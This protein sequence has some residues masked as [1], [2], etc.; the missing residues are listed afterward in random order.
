MNIRRWWASTAALAFA[1]TLAQACSGRGG[2][3]GGLAGGFD[4]TD[5]DAAAVADSSPPADDGNATLPPS[6][7]DASST[8]PAS[9]PRD[10]GRVDGSASRD[11]GRPDAAV[12]VG[13]AGDLDALRQTCVDHINMYRATL[14]LSPLARAT[15]SQEACSDKGAKQDGSTDMAHSSGGMC[16]GFGGQDTCP[17]LPVGGFGNATL[18]SSLIQCLDEMWAEGPPPSGTSVDQCI[19]DY[20]GCFLKHGHYINMS[21]ASYHTVSCGFY[22]I[23][24]ASWWGNQD[25]AY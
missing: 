1:S 14:N 9:K 25:F 2:S 22:E 15:P 20:T 6:A 13:D 21:M 11:A 18:Q 23:S 4:E 12:V 7:D 10:A 19:Q 8:P 5:L 17:D 16:P 3:T 24:S